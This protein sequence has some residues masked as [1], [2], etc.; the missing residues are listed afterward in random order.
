MKK[1]KVKVLILKISQIFAFFVVLIHFIMDLHFTSLNFWF[2]DQK[3]TEIT[4]K[5]IYSFDI[6]DNR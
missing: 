2:S 3:E 6:Y 4:F 1:L 5:N